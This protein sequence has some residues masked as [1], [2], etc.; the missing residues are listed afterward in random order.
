MHHIIHRVKNNVRDKKKRKRVQEFRD[1]RFGVSKAE[2]LFLHIASPLRGVGSRLRAGGRW[3]K[4]DLS[5]CPP[6]ALLNAFFHYLTGVPPP[7]SLLTP[8]SYFLSS[9]FR[10]PSSVSCPLIKTHQKTVFL[11]D[12]QTSVACNNFSNQVPIYF[13]VLRQ[14]PFS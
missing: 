5:L 13:R 10:P 1:S 2:F 11:P 6:P 14:N 3:A 4:K 12:R 8:L 7:S 9:D